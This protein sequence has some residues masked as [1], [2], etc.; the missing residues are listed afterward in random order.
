ME[1][2]ITDVPGL[3]VGHATDPVGLTGC[4]VILCADGAVVG[5]DVRGSAPGTRET[6]LCRPGHLVERA[7]AVLL[8]GG[9][10][11]GLDAAAGC[12]RWLE[13]R[14]MGLPVGV[15]VVPIV[16]AA[17]LFDLSVGDPKAR[18]D[19]AMGY[20][21][22]EAAADGPVAE[23]N[24]GAGT[25]ATVGK[26]LNPAQATKSGLGTAA[27]TMA[28]GV[29]VGAIVVV[30]AVGD[31]YDPDSGEI[32][33]G[34]RGD[35]GFVN[36]TQTLLGGGSTR[37]FPGTNTTIACVATNAR[38]TKEQANKVAQMAHNGLARTIDPIHTMYDG[39]TVFALS[40]GAVEADVTA[41]GTAAALALERAVLR[42]VKKAEA[43]GGLPS[44]RDLG[45]QEE[46]S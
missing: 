10:A 36:I 26:L 27:I 24:V 37:S 11:F 29:V 43:A 23:G 45:P 20:Q 25:G 46:G 5:V 35:G 15:G 16:P 4:T 31:V 30:N 34:A 9:S 17:V 12:M 13:E 18:P 32:V 2:G 6:D 21:A 38:L 14:S 19:A 28:G 8:A 39:D 1:N 41:I 44:A 3:K 22:C 40:Y 7:H 42:A 33:A